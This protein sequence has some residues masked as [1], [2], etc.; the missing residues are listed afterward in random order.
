M[1]QFAPDDSLE[2]PSDEE[3]SLREVKDLKYVEVFDR[4]YDLSGEGIP[5]IEQDPVV[6]GDDY[7][8]YAELS[9]Q[10]TENLRVMN[11]EEDAEARILSVSETQQY[12]V[13]EQRSLQAYDR[14][15]NLLEALTK[16]GVTRTDVLEREL[17]S[18]GYALDSNGKIG[19]ARNSELAALNIHL[20]LPTSDDGFKYVLK[21][22]VSA[23]EIF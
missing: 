9:D 22:G 20:E 14:M 6:L 11:G 5:L 21:P 1:S 23:T 2:E 17:L 19:M 10:A 4:L 3:T 16:R 18:Y 7:S 15:A 8:T 13:L 12:K